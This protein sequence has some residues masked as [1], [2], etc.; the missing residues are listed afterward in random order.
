MLKSIAMPFLP[1][2]TGTESEK[3]KTVSLVQKLAFHWIPAHISAPV[4]VFQSLKMPRIEE[5]SHLVPPIQVVQEYICR[6]LLID[7]HK[8]DLSLG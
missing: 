3:G 6:P 8:W 7:G 5:K 4:T 2:V 1:S